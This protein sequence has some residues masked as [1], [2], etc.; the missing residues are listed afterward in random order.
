MTLPC[1]PPAKACAGAASRAG[2]GGTRVPWYLPS[3]IATALICLAVGLIEPARCGLSRSSTPTSR[4][5]LNTGNTISD[6]DASSH[7]DVARKGMHVRHQHRGA[8]E[9][10][11]TTHTITHGDAG[12]GRLALEWSQHQIIAAQQVE[13]G[14]IK[15]RQLNRTAA[16]AKLEM[17]AR[18]SVWSGSVCC[19]LAYATCDRAPLWIPDRSWARLNALTAVMLEALS[20][21]CITRWRRDLNV[22]Q[23]RRAAYAIACPVWSA[24]AATQRCGT[25]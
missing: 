14:P 3:A 12:T 15:T 16:P 8:L 6:C 23:W 10:R 21:L 24:M 4:E 5:S 11:G 20:S 13:A 18:K 7:D 22:P 9:R 2:R 1:P 17:L 19:R 25:Q